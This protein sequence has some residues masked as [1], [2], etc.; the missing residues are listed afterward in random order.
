MSAILKSQLPDV[1]FRRVVDKD[2]EAI[3]AIESDVYEFPWTAGNFRDAL[4]AGY[5]FWG[6]WHQSP[7]G[8]EL[9]GYGIVMLAV[10]EA[11]LLNLAV[12]RSWQGRGLGRHILHFMMEEASSHEC[13]MLYLEVRPSNIAALQ[14]YESTGFTQ[15]GLRRDYYPARAGREDALFLGVELI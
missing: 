1:R 12:K 9:V 3:A 2:V 15:R 11:H 5:R 4:L 13:V 8:E 6:C 7:Q 10:D 14:L